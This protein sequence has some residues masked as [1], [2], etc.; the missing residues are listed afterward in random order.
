MG[1]DSISFEHA[2]SGVLKASSLEVFSGILRLAAISLAVLF[3]LDA[4][5]FRT[6]WYSDHIEPESYAGSYEYALWNELTR[7]LHGKQHVLVFGDSSIAEGFSAML[8]NRT[9]G[10]RD[11]FFSNVGTPAAT[12]RAWF[13]LLRDLDPD[14]KRYNV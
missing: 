7:P 5:A 8:A 9:E 13:Y 1:A 12:P 2:E 4:L 3:S 6:P 11:C 10:C 14:A